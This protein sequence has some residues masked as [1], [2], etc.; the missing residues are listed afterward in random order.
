VFDNAPLSRTAAIVDACEKLAPFHLTEGDFRSIINYIRENDHKGYYKKRGIKLWDIFK[1]YPG[2][3][4][5]HR[6]IAAPPLPQTSFKRN[7]SAIMQEARKK[8]A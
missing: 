8:Y 5:I 6:L 1:E 4:S 2:W 3:A 7:L